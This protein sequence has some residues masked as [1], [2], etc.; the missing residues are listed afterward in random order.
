MDGDETL[1]KAERFPVMKST[2]VYVVMLRF[3]E[4][5][6]SAGGTYRTFDDAC[7][8]A[9]SI[10]NQGAI[11]VTAYRVVLVAD[12]PIVVAPGEV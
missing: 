8:Y 9:C 3:G 4:A 2:G 5:H 10:G 11:G 6:W 1:L 12:L 7:I